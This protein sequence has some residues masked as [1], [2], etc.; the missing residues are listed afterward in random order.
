MT[1]ISSN[2]QGPNYKR[3]K[4]FSIFSLLVLLFI[5]F[6][7]CLKKKDKKTCELEDEDC[8]KATLVLNNKTGQTIYFNKGENGSGSTFYM[9]IKSGQTISLETNIGVTVRYNEDCTATQS[10]TGIQTIGTPSRYFS[11]T[12]DRCEK[13]ANFVESSGSIDLRE[14]L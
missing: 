1:F 2:N 11:I 7:A 12:M 5:S 6:S 8:D 3:L 4:S 14:E 10:S 9:N 13:R